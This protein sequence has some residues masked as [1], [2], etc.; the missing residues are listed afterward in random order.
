MIGS[1][2]GLWIVLAVVA[3]LAVL[4]VLLALSAVHDAHVPIHAASNVL[5]RTDHVEDINYFIFLLY[6][7]NNNETP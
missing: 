5:H 7:A 4:A 1:M 2:T 3:V 6:N